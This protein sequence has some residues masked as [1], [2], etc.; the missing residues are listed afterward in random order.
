LLHSIG[1]LSAASRRRKFT[2][3]R[4]RLLVQSAGARSAQ[5]KGRGSDSNRNEHFTSN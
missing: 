4:H 5:C 3:E 1:L 2:Q